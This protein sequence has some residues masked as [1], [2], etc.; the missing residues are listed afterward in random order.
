MRRFI[1]IIIGAVLLLAGGSPAQQ[2][3][4]T[5]R[6]PRPATKAELN[7][8]EARLD[9]SKYYYGEAG[10]TTSPRLLYYLAAD[11]KCYRSHPDSLNEQNVKGFAVDSVNKGEICRFQ[12]TGLFSDDD[13][14]WPTIGAKVVNDSLIPG[15]ASEADSLRSSSLKMRVLGSVVAANAIDI[16]IEQTFWIW[17]EP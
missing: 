8:L 15:G 14:N 1:I 17:V 4:S 9:S 5:Y 13:W 11:G 7:A 3:P 2:Y 12:R 10:D 6:G 16:N